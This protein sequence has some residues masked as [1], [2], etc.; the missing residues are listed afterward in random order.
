[1]IWPGAAIF[2][3]FWGCFSAAEGKKEC[4]YL[5]QHLPDFFSLENCPCNSYPAI[6]AKTIFGAPG[7]FVFWCNP[8]VL[9]SPGIKS[10]PAQLFLFKG[11]ELL[12]DC[13]GCPVGWHH[14][15]QVPFP[16]PGSE[17]PLEFWIPHALMSYGCAS[18]HSELPA[19]AL[20]ALRD[21]FIAVILLQIKQFLF[22]SLQITMWSPM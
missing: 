11:H 2:P 6:S 22:F 3:D 4:L 10:C 15:V 5:S 17:S 1:M 7:L 8:C 12:P 13:P 18:P 21:R 20:A 9:P 14:G 16:L 19:G